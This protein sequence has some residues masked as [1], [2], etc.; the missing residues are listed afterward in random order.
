MST[1]RTDLEYLLY[2][3]AVQQPE[4]LDDVER[5]GGGM[6]ANDRLACQRAQ[7]L[8]DRLAADHQART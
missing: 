5:H 2:R 6:L 3:L 8:A 1:V 4:L 7:D